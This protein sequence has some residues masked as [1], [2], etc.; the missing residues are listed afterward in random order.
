MTF[1]VPFF[2][3][4]I[5]LLCVPLPYRMGRS[6]G[7]AVPGRASAPT[8][9]GVF[10]AWQNWVDMLRSLVGCWLLLQEKTILVDAADGSASANAFYLR[11]AILA[12][13]VLIHSIRFGGGLNIYTPV[14]FLSGL[15]VLV[16][17]TGTTD[18]VL[19]GFNCGSK[20]GWFAFGFAWVFALGLRNPIVLLP[21]MGVSLAAAGYLLSGMSVNLQMGI[22]LV[23]LPL[24]LALLTQKKPQ[25]VSRER[26]IMKA[27]QA[28]ASVPKAEPG[29]AGKPMDSSSNILK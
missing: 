1:D 25:I 19:A 9:F 10:C 13:S 16:P 8:M 6:Q 28:K 17:A 20:E 12:G 14:C 5:V 29:A 7:D 27:R 3:A 23:F 2:V 15:T 21:A 24:V 4:A 26:S 18:I 22:G 11:A